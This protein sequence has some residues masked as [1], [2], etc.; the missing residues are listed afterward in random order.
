MEKLQNDV[1]HNI[2]TE[3]EQYGY[4]TFFT[5]EE[6]TTILKVLV[7]KLG[8]EEAGSVILELFFM[9]E[10][11]MEKL[12]DVNF[13]QI[14]ATYDRNV[15]KTAYDDV[16]KALNA[17]NFIAAIG[18]FSVYE[19]QMQLFYKYTCMLT[20][21]EAEELT[22]NLNVVLNWVLGMLEDTYDK[23]CELLTESKK[24]AT[25]NA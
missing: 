25:S 13:L 24:S 14:F 9:N 5:K 6:N 2:K 15:E 11:G 10:D 1:L 21:T 20:G 17:L 3:F 23:M 4:D 12:E 8:E 19:E 16:I 22:G 18:A 7:D